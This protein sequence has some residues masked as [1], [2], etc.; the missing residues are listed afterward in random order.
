L[1]SCTAAV[2]ILAGKP[3]GRVELGDALAQFSLLAL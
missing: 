1:I 2:N 3:V